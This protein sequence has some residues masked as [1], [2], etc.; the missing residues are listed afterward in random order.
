MITIKKKVVS[1]SIL[2]L[3]ACTIDVNAMRL[4]EFDYGAASVFPVYTDQ[5]KKYVILSREARGAD[6]ETYDDFGGRRDPE[7]N[8]PFI[9]AAREWME[10]GLVTKITGLQFPEICNLI[11]IAK[12]SNKT[13]CI[14]AYTGRKAKNVTYITDVTHYKDKLIYDFY[15]VLR[16]AKR[17]KK[18]KYIEKDSIAVVE[19]SELVRVLQDAMIK[20]QHKVTNI[21]MSAFILNE[22]TNKLEKGIIKLRPFFVSK[23]RPYF[24]NWPYQEGKDK[25]IRFYAFNKRPSVKQVPAAKQSWGAWLKSFVVRKPAGNQAVIKSAN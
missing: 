21:T 12:K 8:H 6:K 2:L 14:V 18:A 24:L 10:E 16:K 19:L 22:K 7:E 3:V 20:D 13:E 4:S 17:I 9:T 25:K 1:I 15:G 11:D 23:I 5:G